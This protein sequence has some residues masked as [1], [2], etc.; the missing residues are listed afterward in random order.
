MKYTLEQIENMIH[1]IGSDCTGEGRNRFVTSGD[2]EHLDEL[3]E[4]G[5]ATKRDFGGMAPD[6]SK[7]YQITP[8]GREFLQRILNAFRGGDHWSRVNPTEYVTCEC[9]EEDEDDD[10]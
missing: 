3:V 10:E 8:Q 2:E 7:L 1:A 6:G 9:C 5:D 4:S